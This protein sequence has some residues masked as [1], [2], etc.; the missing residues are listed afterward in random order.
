LAAAATGAVDLKGVGNVSKAMAGRHLSGPGLDIRVVHLDRLPA[1]ATHDVVVLLQGA[2]TVP[3]LS[4]TGPDHVDLAVLVEGLQRPVNGRETDRRSVG[5]EPG[6]DV[7][8]AAEL[9]VYSSTSLPTTAGP[10]LSGSATAALAALVNCGA[11]DDKLK[12][13]GSLA[14][15]S[16]PAASRWRTR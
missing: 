3:S 8:R 9:L 16:L 6:V 2:A 14:G 10:S 5:A 4:L 15:L 1:V 11:P 7:L 13:N 12:L